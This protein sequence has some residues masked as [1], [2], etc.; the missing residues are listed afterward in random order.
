MPSHRLCTSTCSG[1]EAGVLC[2]SHPDVAKVAFTGSVA[3]GKAVNAA[4]AQNLVP[5]TMELGGKS[6]M[7]VFDDADIDKAVEWVAV[8]PN[9]YSQFH[10]HC[11][12]ASGTWGVAA[13]RHMWQNRPC[14]IRDH[15]HICTNMPATS[16]KPSLSQCASDQPI[17]A[18]G[19]GIMHGAQTI[20]ASAWHPH[21]LMMP[22]LPC[23]SASLPMPV[24][25][26]AQLRG[27]CCMPASPTASC[28]S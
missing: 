24:R 10:L 4:A 8:R 6:P 7:I 20:L 28:R 16:S 3:T 27:C 2:S 13:C 17:E 11:S 23:S 25:S 26:A 15:Q 19:Y 22:H 12:S 9:V 5:V 18:M 21:Q 14:A 1:S